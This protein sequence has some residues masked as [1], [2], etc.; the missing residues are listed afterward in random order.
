[1]AICPHCKEQIQDYAKKCPHC[2]LWVTKGRRLA[3]AVKT[4][5]ECATFIAAICVLW[6]MYRQN[7]MMKEQL[8][9]FGRQ[10]LE[11]LRPRIEISPPTIVASDS[12]MDIYFD[13]TNKGHSD[14]ENILILVTHKLTGV[15]RDSQFVSEYGKIG[16]DSKPINFHQLLQ[17]L[18]KGDFFS[19][20]DVRYGWPSFRQN[21]SDYK[22]YEH[23][24]DKRNRTFHSYRIDQIQEKE[25]GF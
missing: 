5:L 3:G 7:T 6:V 21:F 22:W 1:M 14:A 11:E 24:Y 20:I 8:D 18:F 4:I 10:T 25:L 23:F 19:K 9:L 13:I 15:G 12:G 17:P 2:G 16:A